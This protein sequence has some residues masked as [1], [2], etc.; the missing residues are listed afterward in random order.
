MTAIL[1]K[2][3]TV[4]YPAYALQVAVFRWALLSRLEH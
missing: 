1:R 4:H 3:V 2:M